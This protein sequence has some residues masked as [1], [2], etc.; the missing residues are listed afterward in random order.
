MTRTAVLLSVLVLFLLIG[1]PLLYAR[2][3]HEAYRNLRVVDEGV[4]YR[5]GQ[6]SMAGFERVCREKGVRTVIKL[7]DGDD[8]DP[9]DL[10]LDAAEEA[11]CH[12]HGIAF[13]RLSP[14]PWE[15]DEGMLAALGGVAAI[16]PKVVPM[17]VNLREFERLITSAE[18]TPRAVLVHC[19]AGIHRT[20]ALVAVYRVLYDG[21]TPDE[22]VAELQSCGKPTT[23]YVGN[24]IPFLATR[25]LPDL[26]RRVHGHPVGSDRR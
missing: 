2:Q 9:K 3:R 8:S 26:Y 25:Y 5:S 14:R 7:R 23:T 17:W 20:G 19:F 18:R 24:L 16:E 15:V 1:F 6:M 12:A 4:L 22:A 10:A 21:Y 13:V 11:H